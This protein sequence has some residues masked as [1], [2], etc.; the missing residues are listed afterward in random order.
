MIAEQTLPYLFPHR[1]NPSL[2]L[3]K[4]EWMAVTLT[5]GHFHI[6]ATEFQGC[7]PF[8]LVLQFS[9]QKREVPTFRVSMATW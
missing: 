2:H 8:K 1:V 9:R 6:L 3:N 5:H 4:V 7:V